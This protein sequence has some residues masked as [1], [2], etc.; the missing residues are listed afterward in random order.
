MFRRKLARLYVRNRGNIFYL[1]H[2]MGQTTLEM[3]QHYVEV[4]D[5]ELQEMHQKTSLLSR[6]R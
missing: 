5:A 6:L 2:A 1:M 4:E 3:T